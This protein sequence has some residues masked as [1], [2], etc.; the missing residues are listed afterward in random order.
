M[1]SVLANPNW[2]FVMDTWLQWRWPS[3]RLFGWYFVNSYKQN[4]WR[5]PYCA[6]S[7]CLWTV[8]RLQMT[9]T[10]LRGKLL[11]MNCAP[12]ADDIHPTVDWFFVFELC[13]VC[14]WH[15]PNCRMICCIRTVLH[16]QVT[17]TQ[18]RDDLLS[19]LVAGHET[20]GSALTWTLYLLV[21]NPEKMAKAQVCVCVCLCP[22][23]C[24]CLCVCVCMCVCV[25]K[26]LSI[27]WR[28]VYPVAIA[29]K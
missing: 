11:S 9:S 21:Q 25:C 1:Y 27:W 2:Y 19:M 28:H 8:P 6:T 5:P 4:W 13:P 23:V 24:L 22:C 29:Y 12:F 18:L 26:Y 10:L 16:L 20:T 15:L 14:K 7:C 3:A 17:S